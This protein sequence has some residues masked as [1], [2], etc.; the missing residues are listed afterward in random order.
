MAPRQSA[1]KPRQTPTAGPSAPDLAA[2]T[3]DLLSR[4]ISLRQLLKA[5]A[6][7]ALA[8]AGRSVLVPGRAEATYTPG[9][10]SDIVDTNLLV[11]GNLTVDGS[12]GLGTATP[13]GRLDVAG[14]I[15]NNTLVLIGSDG[16]GKQCYY[17][18]GPAYTPPPA[19]STGTWGRVKT[20]TWQAVGTMTWGALQTM[21][22]TWDRVGAHTWGYLSAR[23]WYEVTVL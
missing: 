5:A 13:Q 7:A 8:G 18:A 23:S 19:T 9:T 22:G 3:G 16:R 12:V 11:Q 17:A 2:V 1:G 10:P 4:R 14:E 15:R 20:T 21:N 6:V